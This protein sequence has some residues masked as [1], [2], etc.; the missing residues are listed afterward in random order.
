MF[1]RIAGDMLH[2]ASLLILAFRIRNSK[3]CVGISCKTQEL[4]M[5]VFATRYLDL[6]LYF[7]SL[8]NT[9]MKVAYLII[10]GYLIYLM[11]FAKLYRQTYDVKGDSFQYWKWLLGPCFVLSMIFNVEFT[12]VEIMWSFSIFLEAVAFVPQLEMMRKMGRVENL[13]SHYVFTLGGY[14]LLYIFSW[15]AKIMDNEPISWI[16]LSGGVVQTILYADFFYY[17]ILAKLKGDKSVALPI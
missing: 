16:S 13:T 7:V 15:V 9:F 2:V 3:N 1:F 14:R 4:Y 5:I 8:Y 17:Y 12:F 10:T 6:F 11:R